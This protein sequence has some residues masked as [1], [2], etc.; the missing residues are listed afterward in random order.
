M[1][2]VVCWR[3]RRRA[4]ALCGCADGLSG[5]RRDRPMAEGPRLR[6]QHVR[7]QVRGAIERASDSPIALIHGC[8]LEGTPAAEWGINRGSVPS[9]NLL[10]R[11]TDGQVGM[12]T[13]VVSDGR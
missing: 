6:Q 5:L 7:R 4:T 11:A 9:R 8:P 13:V 2:S 12:T 1:S 3:Q 10:V